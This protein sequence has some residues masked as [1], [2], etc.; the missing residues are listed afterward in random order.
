MN[1]ESKDEVLSR[2]NYININIMLPEQPKPPLTGLGK[3]QHEHDR[4]ENDL[5][6]QCL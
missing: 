2:I 3:E 1:A 4:L 5:F 6:E